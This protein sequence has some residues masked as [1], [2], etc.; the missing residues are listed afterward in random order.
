M[1]RVNPPKIWRN[2]VHTEKYIMRVWNYMKHEF[3]WTYKNDCWEANISEFNQVWVYVVE[4]DG[5]LMQCWILI[6][7]IGARYGHLFDTYY[8]WVWLKS[9]KDQGH[10]NILHSKTTHEYFCL[11]PQSINTQSC[12]WCNIGNF[13]RFIPDKWEKFANVLGKSSWNIY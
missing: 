7:H 6:F 11:C 4:Q 13:W 3:H 9:T 8:W 5:F 12:T 10:V 1:R 2:Y